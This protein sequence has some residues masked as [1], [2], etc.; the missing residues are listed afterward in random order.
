MIPS[1]KIAISVVPAK[2]DED[3]LKL[4]IF[5]QVILSKLVACWKSEYFR[6]KGALIL[7]LRIVSRVVLG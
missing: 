2:I 1:C 3:A 5:F 7:E 6:T 4:V